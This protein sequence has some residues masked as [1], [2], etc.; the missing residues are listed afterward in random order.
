VLVAQVKRYINVGRVIQHGRE[1]L[2]NRRLPLLSMDIGPVLPSMCPADESLISPIFY[3]RG[4]RR[5]GAMRHDWCVAT[6]LVSVP[7]P[8]N[9][10]DRLD[11]LASSTGRSA[12][13]YVREALEEYLAELEYAYALRAD[14]DGALEGRLPT[15][16]ASDLWT[17]LGL[18][19]EDLA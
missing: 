8:T 17:E 12:A 18:S 15:R 3:L 16:P 6:E 1:G 4:V 19:A 13:S 10:K 5:K 14:A 7:L 2:L 11:A 9:L